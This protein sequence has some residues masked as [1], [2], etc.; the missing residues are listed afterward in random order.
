MNRLLL[1]SSLSALV[2]VAGCGAEDPGPGY[3]PTTDPYG[4]NPDPTG[5]TPGPTGATDTMMLTVDPLG[6]NTTCYE[7]VAVQ[8]TATPG[9]DVYAI[10]GASPSDIRTANPPDGRFCVDVPL[11]KNQI[12]EIE[13]WAKHPDLGP[14][15]PVK[16]TV[17]HDDGAA[18]CTAPEEPTEEPTT[19]TELPNIA[20]GARVSSKDSPYENSS[21][22]ITDGDLKT[23]AAWGGGDWYNPLSAYNGWVIVS[24][25][26][27]AEV[28]KVVVHWRDAKGVGEQQFGKEYEFWYSAG[29]AATFDK[30]SGMWVNPSNG[31]VTSGDGGKD[32]F[33]LKGEPLR[34]VAL[35][36]LQDGADGWNENF[37]I[38]EIEILARPDDGGTTTYVPSRPGS[39]DTLGGF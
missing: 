12:N 28:E 20:Q 25:D 31:H 34:Q 38:S 24:L 9:S 6:S 22:N 26:Q 11:R 23:W 27:V 39:C 29:D 1:A 37:A 14:A 17:I 3:D 32:E 2:I 4:T 8:G 15:D 7:S 36:L 13:V 35:L 30:N 10:G 18:G 16:I 21:P 5:T 33:S 19:P